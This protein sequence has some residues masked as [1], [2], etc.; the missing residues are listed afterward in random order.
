[1]NEKEIVNKID[2]LLAPFAQYTKKASKAYRNHVIRMALFAHELVELDQKSSEKVVIAAVFHDLGI[3]TDKTF[4]YLAPSE[5]LAETYLRANGLESYS[6][7]VKEMISYH[8]K[9]RTFKDN[10]LV[11]TFR[12]ADLIDVYLGLP[13]FGIS[14]Q[15]IKEIRNAYPNSGFHKALIKLASLQLLKTPWNPMPMIKF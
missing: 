4:D 2:T 8:H 14:K 13:K 5:A 7:E 6:K 3:W 10:N 11:E 15:R 12:K 9:I 1:M